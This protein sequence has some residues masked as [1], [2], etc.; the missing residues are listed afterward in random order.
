ML[1]CGVPRN[2]QCRKAVK[3][4]AIALNNMRKKSSN[5]RN[6]VVGID[7]ASS[8]FG[9]RAEVF[10]QAYRY[11]KG[12][13]FNSELKFLKDYS[14]QNL[15]FTFHAGEDYYDI[16]D[17]LRAI[18]ETIRFLNFGRG[19]RIGHALALGINT[20]DFYA[21]KH[22]RILISQQELLDNVAWLLNS[23]SCYNVIVK[24]S[25]Q[26]LLKE[27]FYDYCVRIYGE[28]IELETYFN[29]YCL[30]GD[31]P[32]LYMKDNADEY[33][34]A[35]N[36]MTY[37]YRVG[38][39]CDASAIRA[40]HDKEARNLYRRYHYDGD[41]KK[42][43]SDFAEF[44]ISND[45]VKMVGDIQKALAFELSEKGVVIETNPSSNHLISSYKYYAKHPIFSFFNTGLVND[46]ELLKNNPQLSVS[47]NTDDSGVFAT[48]IENEYAM[49]AVA[50]YKEKTHNDSF[51]NNR[52]VCDWLDR[53]RTMG[54][55]QRFKK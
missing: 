35:P 11:L 54:F 27:T 10:A 46:Y 3:R 47:I 40:R 33:L 16:V 45:Y 43:G 24:S 15:G 25:L 42:K 34:D 17:G 32:R 50:L 1:D 20:N 41:V 14:F 5:I 48:S 53:I 13:D 51:Y 18:D 52:Y 29:S 49:L 21:S 23:I 31:M 9:C 19:D 8:E 2:N 39:N 7:S 26:K 36:P 12:Y 38:L 55:E 22:Y 28:P 37:W 30:R 6:R 4:Q 44:H